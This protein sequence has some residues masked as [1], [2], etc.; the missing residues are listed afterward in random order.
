MPVRDPGKNY[1]SGG[2]GGS[3]FV[4]MST[5]Q[6]N[7]YKIH[8]LYYGNMGYGKLNKLASAV[9]HKFRIKLVPMLPFGSAHQMPEVLRNK[10]IH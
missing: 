6:C 5:C 8:W 10:R 7:V 3:R 2:V 1:R 4:I 9:R